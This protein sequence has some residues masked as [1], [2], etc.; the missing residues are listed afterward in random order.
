MLVLGATSA[1]RR[2]QTTTSPASQSRRCSHGRCGA[3]PPPFLPLRLRSRHDRRD[4]LAEPQ[5]GRAPRIRHGLVAHR[6]RRQGKT[7]L[8]AQPPR[9]CRD[10]PRGGARAAPLGRRLTRSWTSRPTDTTSG[11]TARRGSTSLLG[12]SCGPRTATLS[13]VPHLGR[14]PRLRQPRGDDGLADQSA[15]SVLDVARWQR[16]YVNLNPHGEPQLGRR[17][18]YRSTGGRK[19][20][21]ARELALLWVLNLSDRDHTLLDI[22]E[23]SGLEFGTV[24]AAADALIAAEL[25]EEVPR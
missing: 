13:R 21:S 19:D 3:A 4:R 23:R 17:G 2:W 24:R 15:C 12:A 6:R 20:E 7:D 9:R 5:P 18:L 16:R 25:L 1:I 11:S 14:Q 22:A 10:R 8:Q